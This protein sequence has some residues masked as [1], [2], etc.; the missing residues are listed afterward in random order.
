MAIAICCKSFE[1]KEYF[2]AS[3]FETHRNYKIYYLLSGNATYHNINGARL[4][5]SSSD[6]VLIPPYESYKFSGSALC[7]YEVCF[8][9]EDVH[10]SIFPEVVDCFSKYGLVNFGSR[11]T[12]ERLDI[13]KLNSEISGEKKYKNIACTA[14][15]QSFLLEIIRAVGRKNENLE[16]KNGQAIASVIDYIDKNFS[17]KITIND[18]ANVACMS[19]SHFACNFK[20]YTGMTPN[21]YLN[22]VRISVAVKYV[23]LPSMTMADVAEKVGMKSASYFCSQFKKYM[24]MS[25][26]K[27]GEMSDAKIFF[28]DVENDFEKQ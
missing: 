26:R 20:K 7:Y 10:S 16:S 12:A 28:Y 24:K 11:T 21:D 8:D 2:S 22:K 17:S 25:P 18:M 19:N 13:E 15:L 4:T 3:S 5:M 6:A 14:L 1:K 27:Y 23:C 9:R